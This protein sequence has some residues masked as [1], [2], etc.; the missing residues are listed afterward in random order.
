MFDVLQRGRIAEDG[1]LVEGS[2]VLDA[3]CGTGAMALEALSQGAERATMM[4]LGRG[5]AQTARDNILALNE[6]AR[7][8]VIEAD[9]ANPPPVRDRTRDVATLVFIDPPYGQNLAPDALT[10]LAEA[11]WIA[12]GA[13]AVV[14]IGAKE[15]FVPPDGF[16]LIDERRYGAARIMFCRYRAQGRD[17]GT[18]RR[19]AAI[20]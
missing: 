18:R 6:T 15:G 19:D 4:D 12:D 1:S 2:V 16:A 20:A 8:H 11:G 9:P 3:Y 7:A 13:V 14:E 17:D 10:R 5:A